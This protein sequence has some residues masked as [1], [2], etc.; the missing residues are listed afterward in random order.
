MLRCT[1]E[2]GLSFDWIDSFAARYGGNR[3]KRVG[4]ITIMC[5]PA[6]H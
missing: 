2:R 3:I 5:A 6:R 1:V 4:R